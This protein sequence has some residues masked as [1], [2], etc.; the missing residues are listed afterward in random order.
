VA[1][2]WPAGTT[3]N[4]IISTIASQSGVTRLKLD[5]LSSRVTTDKQTNRPFVVER[6][7][8]RG[9]A[10]SRLAVAKG[11]DIYFDTLGY[12]TTQDFY[13]AADRSVVYTYDPDA[14]N[15][16]L[17]VKA[18]YTDDNLYNAVLV[19]AKKGTITYLVRD[20]DPTSVTSVNRLGE[21]LFIYENEDITTLTL[22][23]QV[24]NRL[25]YQKVV[26]NEDITLETLCNPAFEGND[27][28][29]VRED[30]SGLNGIY[31]IKAF[32][33]PMSSS[34]QTIRLLREVNLS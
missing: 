2:T 20:T 6:G 22:A 21:R 24:G 17:T 11:L 9:E 10:L 33:V 23:R 8:N 18:S 30:F 15:N 13:S 7:D 27:V 28:I 14:N 31:R 5:P 32:T 16:L 26:V 1:K 12:L 34:R 25:F 19:V 29:R 3:I 4:S